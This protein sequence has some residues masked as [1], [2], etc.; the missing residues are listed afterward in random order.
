ME[1]YSR[2]GHTFYF[3][4]V[5]VVDY[6]RIFSE[7]LN[8]QS[9]LFRFA[10]GVSIWAGISVFQTLFWVGVYAPIIENK[11]AQFTDICS[12]AN[13]RKSMIILKASINVISRYLIHNMY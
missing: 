2:L 13:I 7:K 10:L 6:E 3:F 4:H 1:Q 8:R 5:V 9:F 11:L 12:L